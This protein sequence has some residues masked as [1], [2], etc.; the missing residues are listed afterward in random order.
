MRDAP[1]S[2]FTDH[3]LPGAWARN[4]L[5]AAGLQNYQEPVF[6]GTELKSS[7][8]ERFRWTT[9][10]SI[11]SKLRVYPNPARDYIIVEY[12]KSVATDQYSIVFL[13]SNGKQIS[14]F[15]LSKSENQQVI[16][17]NDLRSGTYLIQLKVNQSP[18]ESCKV[19]VIR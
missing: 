12:H 6:S 17:I 16:P 13:D 3:D 18:K 4:I 9:A 10:H 15:V 5:I 1:A 8:K 7:R 2:F 14:T 11:D 19:V